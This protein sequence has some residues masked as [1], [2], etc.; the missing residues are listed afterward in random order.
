MARPRLSLGFNKNVIR[1]SDKLS[2]YFTYYGL[3]I[4]MYVPMCT[5]TTKRSLSAITV[6]RTVRYYLLYCLVTSNANSFRKSLQWPTTG[7]IK[8]DTLR[9]SLI[10]CRNVSLFSNFV[11]LYFLAHCSTL[12]IVLFCNVS[13]RTCMKSQKILKCNFTKKKSR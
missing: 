9:V 3:C 10:W 5:T 7:H 4:T 1:V 6:T 13:C 8:L 12:K 2:K 11:T